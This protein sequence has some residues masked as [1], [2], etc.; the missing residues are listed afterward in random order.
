MSI[1]LTVNHLL[2]TILINSCRVLIKKGERRL[3]SNGEVFYLTDCR[4]YADIDTLE[5][6]VGMD[7]GFTFKGKA[8]VILV[9]QYIRGFIVSQ[10]KTSPR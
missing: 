6:W 7:Y 9:S 1:T 4:K 3:I 5:P 8:V 2:L 10:T